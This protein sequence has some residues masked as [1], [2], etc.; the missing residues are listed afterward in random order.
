MI[1]KD[2]IYPK[3]KLKYHKKGRG[4]RYNL[5]CASCRSKNIVLGSQYLD[6]K[7]ETK[8]L[9]E[10]CTIYFYKIDH[11]FRTLKAAALRR[12]RMFDVAYLFEE[13]LMDKYVEDKKLE[14]YENLSE[15]EFNMFLS[16][17]K[18]LYNELFTKE[19]K[20]SLEETIDQKNIE[21]EIIKK[22]NNIEF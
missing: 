19:E 3:I 16:I 14:S 6:K 7:G 13:I 20:E 1:K 15:E 10:D 2:T 18:D 11:D 4:I 12:R 5:K 17:A 22:L 9:C 21:E 8:Y